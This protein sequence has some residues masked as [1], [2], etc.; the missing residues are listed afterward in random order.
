MEVVRTLRILE[1]ICCFSCLVGTSACTEVGAW[2][3]PNQEA[4]QVEESTHLSRRA[5]SLRQGLLEPNRTVAVTDRSAAILFQAVEIPAPGRSSKRI[6]VF[7]EHARVDTEKFAHLGFPWLPAFCL[8]EVNGRVT[9]SAMAFSSAASRS[10][11]SGLLRE[12]TH[13]DLRFAVET[14]SGGGD[15]R[16][17]LPR[18]L[19]IYAARFRNVRPGVGQ[20]SGC[21]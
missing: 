9:T 3:W 18:L 21:C 11:M 19:T 6:F 4:S 16:S 2:R 12:T 17:M 1:N 7:A 15:R 10:R 13:D 5:I 20:P 14:P 8:L